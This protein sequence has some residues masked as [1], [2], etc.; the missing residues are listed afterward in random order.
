VPHRAVVRLLREFRSRIGGEHKPA[1]GRPIA[2][3]NEVDV[4]CVRGLLVMNRLRTCAKLSNDIHIESS[5]IHRNLKQN[6]KKREISA[7]WYH[8]V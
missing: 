6:L 5:S 7:Q 4:A 3:A 8:D 2:A 1:A